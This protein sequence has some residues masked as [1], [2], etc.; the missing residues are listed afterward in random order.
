VP[1]EGYLH[2]FVGFARRTFQKIRSTL[3]PQL[4]SVKAKEKEDF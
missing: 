3:F 2:F 4:G 1:K